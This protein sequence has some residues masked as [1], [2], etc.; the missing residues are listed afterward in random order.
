MRRLRDAG[1]EEFVRWYLA[2]ERRKRRQPEDSE[3]RHWDPILAEM[4]GAH[5]DK[6]R[7]WFERARWSVVSLESIEEAASLVCV[8]GPETRRNKLITGLGPDHRLAR[9]VVAAAR[10]IGYFDND[11]VSKSN[12]VEGH[13]R[14]E[15][16]EAFRRAW[17][18]FEKAERLTLCTLNAGE[19]LENPGGSYYLHDGFGRLLAWLYAI[20]YEGREYQPIEAFLAEE[21]PTGDF[22]RR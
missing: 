13:F 9:N 19:R 12:A 4:R 22:S 10:A 5:P 21:A 2:R 11:E 17:P 3:R 16:L 20:V 18:R 7:P 1:F 6:L 15:R 8:D 14:Q